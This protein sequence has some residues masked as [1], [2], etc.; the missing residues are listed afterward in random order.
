[1]KKTITCIINGEKKMIEIN[2]QESLLEVLRDRLN[3][4]GAKKGCEVGECGACTV[5][6]D[7][8]AVDSCLYLAAWADGKEI[9]TVEGLAKNGK[10]SALQESFIEEG[11]VQCGY[12]SPGFLMSAYVL[13]KDYQTPTEEDIRRG[14]SGNFCRCTGYENIIKAVQKAAVKSLGD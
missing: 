8:K 4:T 7:G 9:L 1:M 6:V 3:L 12:C 5:V 10:L 2:V 13:L 14:L 11:A